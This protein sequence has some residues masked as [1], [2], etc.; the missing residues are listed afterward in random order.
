MHST[1]QR[2]F[3]YIYLTY[4]LWTQAEDCGR[5][6]NYLVIYTLHIPCGRR[7]RTASG[8]SAEDRERPISYQRTS[9]KKDLLM[10]YILVSGPNNRAICLEQSGDMF[11]TIERWYTPNRRAVYSQQSSGIFRRYIPN[12]RAVYSQQSS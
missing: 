12:S 3:P 5:P 2:P 1:P 7:L 9:A 4:T 6:I 11:R 10:C 8:R